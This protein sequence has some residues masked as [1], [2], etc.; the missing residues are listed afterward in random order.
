MVYS[1]SL[2]R[3]HWLTDHKV[4]ACFCIFNYETIV[5]YLTELCDEQLL[6]SFFCKHCDINGS[7][8]CFQV[9]EICHIKNSFTWSTVTHYGV[10]KNRITH[11]EKHTTFMTVQVC[12]CNIDLSSVHAHGAKF[13]VLG[14]IT[15]QGEHRVFRNKHI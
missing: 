10:Y 9:Y 6:L 14:K 5:Q 12:T 15:P 11:R 7:Y 4:P 3:F 13:S 2:Q 8:F 1:F